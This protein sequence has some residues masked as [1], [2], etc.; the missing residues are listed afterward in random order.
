MVDISIFHYTPLF[1]LYNHTITLRL[2]KRGQRN[3]RYLS[4]SANSAP[5]EYSVKLWLSHQPSISSSYYV[6][7]SK[8]VGTL[9]F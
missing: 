3:G 2:P 8:L 5:F 9:L 4:P 1:P 7:H 6:M